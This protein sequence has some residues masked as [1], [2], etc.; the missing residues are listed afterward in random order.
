[1]PEDTPRYLVASS[2]SR[3]IHHRK[4]M[5]IFSA[6]GF[7]IMLLILSVVMRPVFIELERTA[8]AFLAGARISAEIATQIAASA[9]EIRFPQE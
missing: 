7:G 1:M 2:R 3:L 6:I 5:P 8:V 9:A 4:I